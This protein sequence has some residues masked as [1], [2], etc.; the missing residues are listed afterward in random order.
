MTCDLGMAIA[1]ITL[2]VDHLLRSPVGHCLMDVR[3]MRGV[4][5][6]I[7]LGQSHWQF[8]V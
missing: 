5:L 6:V 4:K 7:R 1:F 8:R 2:V 3:E